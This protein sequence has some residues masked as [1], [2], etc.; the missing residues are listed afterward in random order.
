MI[1]EYQVL[2]VRWNIVGLKKGLLNRDDQT[3]DPDGN[4]LIYEQEEM[5]R[6]VWEFI[7][8]HDGNDCICGNCVE[9]IAEVLVVSENGS[10]N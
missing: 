1:D 8:Q 4:E 9:Q 7:E 5:G 3:H 2:R 10:R 6:N